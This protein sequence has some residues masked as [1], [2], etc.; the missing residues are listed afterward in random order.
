[1]FPKPKRK[2]ST[3]ANRKWREALKEGKRNKYSAQR[4]ADGFPSRLEARTYQTLLLREKAGEIR[5]LRRQHTIR[6]P[7]GPGWKV[8]FSFVDCATGETVFCEAKGQELETYRLKKSM[9]CGCPVLE[10]E[11]KLEVWKAGKG[12]DPVLTD[13]VKPKRV[14]TGGRKEK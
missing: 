5:D 2:P 1:M 7:C 9:Y 10:H 14:P 3:P 6:F 13:E 8:D 11:G 12:G 4:T